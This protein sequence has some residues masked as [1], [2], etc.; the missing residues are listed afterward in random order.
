MRPKKTSSPKWKMIVL[1]IVL[2]Q[3]SLLFAANPMQYAT[4]R[5]ASNPFA[6]VRNVLIGTVMLVPAGIYSVSK[7]VSHNHTQQPEPTGCVP[8]C[9][10]PVDCPNACM[11]CCDGRPCEV[12]NK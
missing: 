3:T 8:C 2:L 6:F 10:D 1:G 9:F 7:A 4:Q 11:S 12:E 5:R